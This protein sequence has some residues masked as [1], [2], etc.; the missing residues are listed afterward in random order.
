MKY[1]EQFTS[2]TCAG[3]ANQLFFST[4]DDGL[5]TGRVFYKINFGGELDYSFLFTNIIDSTFAD[6]SVSHNNILCDQWF[7]GGARVGK[8]KDIPPVANMSRLTVADLGEGEAD[9]TVCEL[10]E[11]SFGGC[12][13]KTVMPGEFFTTD[14]VR[15][16]FNKGEY[17][18]LE[19]SFCGKMIPYHEE[20]LLPIFIKDGDEWR[21]SR[22]MPLAAM[23]GCKREVVARIGYL[24]DSITQGIG[25]RY[26]S[27]LHWNALVSERLGDKYSYWNLGIGYG[28]ASDAA[29]DGAWL[30]KA[31]AC[32]I[33][34][35]CYGTNDI[36]QGHSE[37][38]IK[39]DIYRITKL[40]KSSGKRVILQTLPPF[41]YTGD[42]VGK[43][44]RINEFIKT[45]LSSEA[46]LV[47]DVVPILEKEGCPAAA[48][49]GGHPNEE[50]C[51]LW[52]QALLSA[53]SD[54][55]S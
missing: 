55:V 10:T 17:I 47:F 51:A 22:R 23:V 21:Y 13:S 3:S 18:C 50:G 27:Y 25:T 33:V 1:F 28:R 20:S 5:T 37:E 9:I 19:I 35:V 44:Q 36:L 53:V 39:S 48:K 8:C 54:L 7:I 46:D 45:T 31:K 32:D 30:F 49:F 29:S 2:N 11:L 43:W 42:N 40:L 41:D 12:K 15:L 4:E 14:P 34:F 52:A 24:G 16:S 38:Q 6:G 26:N